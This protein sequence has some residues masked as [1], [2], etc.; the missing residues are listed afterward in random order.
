MALLYRAIWEDSRRDLVDVAADAM[1]EWLRIKGMAV[2]GLVEGET[3]A[4]MG[5]TV[6][7]DVVTGTGV[8]GVRRA[9]VDG[10]VAMRARLVEERPAEGSR[11]TSTLSVVAP[12]SAP[13]GT[14][15]VDIERVSDDPFSRA[16]FRAPGIVRMLVEDAAAGGGDP[17]VGHVRLSSGPVAIPAMQLAGLVRNEE[18]RL[19]LAVFSHD[20]A[21]IDTTMRRARS[22]YIRVVGVSQVYLL[23]SDQVDAFRALVGDELGVWGG[24]ARLYLPNRG[25]LGLRPDRHRYVAGY[26][27]A[28]SDDAAGEYFVSLLSATVPATV[29]PPVFDRV[30]RELVVGGGSRGLD[31]LLEEAIAENDRLR[32]E[33]EARDEEIFELQADNEELETALNRKAGEINRLFASFGQAPATAAQ[34]LPDDVDTIEDALAF[35]KRLDHIEVHP[36]APRDIDKLDRSINAR[37]WANSLWRGLRALD[38]YARNDEQIAGGFWEWCANNTSS[39]WSWPATQKKLSMTESETVRNSDR[40]RR[41]RMLPIS[42]EV[43][44]DGQVEM[45]SHLKIAEGGGPMAP[46]VYFYDDTDGPTKKVHIGFVGPHE[47]MPNTRTN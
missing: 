26:R 10:L 19:P 36:D 34:D 15:W 41:A 18:R 28:K 11:W 3:E 24:A 43:R 27:M 12:N 42:R 46:R 9:V 33:L 30:R 2:D 29:P 16:P 1:V 21:G 8:L 23:L 6:H 47:H 31:A 4:E 13:G 22:A 32:V 7:G 5:R 44:D 20:E 40:L 45:F 35:A 37:A 39:A 14:L 38:A 25:P 17:R